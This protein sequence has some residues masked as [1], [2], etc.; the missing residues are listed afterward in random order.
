[1]LLQRAQLILRALLGAP[2]LIT[3]ELRRVLRGHLVG[4]RVA[5]APWGRLHAFGGAVGVTLHVGGG[6]E[7]PPLK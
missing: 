4:R 5:P 1:M 6:S 7:Q 3:V 2:L